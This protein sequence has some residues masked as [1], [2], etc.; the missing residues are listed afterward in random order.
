MQHSPRVN[1]PLAKQILYEFSLMWMPRLVFSFS[2]L[3]KSAALE[4]KGV[5]GRGKLRGSVGLKPDLGVDDRRVTT[6]GLGGAT[7]PVQTWHC[8]VVA[9]A[10]R[11][12]SALAEVSV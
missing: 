8:C 11:V 4:Y 2:L 6:P 10:T 12:W 5:E 9:M 1:I 7:I 3:E